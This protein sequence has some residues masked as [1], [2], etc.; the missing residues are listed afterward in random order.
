MPRLDGSG[1]E[2]KGLMTG[3]KMGNCKPKE[4]TKEQEPSNSV[5][6]KFVYPRRGQQGTREPKGNGR[7]ARARF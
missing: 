2:G 3:R 1:P 5:N 7:R 4:E 6:E